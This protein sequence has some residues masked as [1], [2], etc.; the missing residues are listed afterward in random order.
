LQQAL[1]FLS[2]LALS[3]LQQALSS[4]FSPQVLASFLQQALAS[5]SQQA[6]AF[7]WQHSFLLWLLSL[8]CALTVVVMHIIAI[9][10]AL[11]KIFFMLVFLLML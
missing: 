5:F 9:T 10:M 2:Q 4:F 11:N 8:D 6:L 3:F 7:F 1:A